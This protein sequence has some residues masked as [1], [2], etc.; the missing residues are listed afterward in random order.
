VCAFAECQVRGPIRAGVKQAGAIAE[1]LRVHVGGRVAHVDGFPGSDR[2]AV[3]GHRAAG[4]DQVD[5]EHQPA[6]AALIGQAAH[7][8]RPPGG[9]GGVPVVA[10]FQDHA[11][12]AGRRRGL[13]LVA[14]DDQ[15]QLRGQLA[16]GDLAAVARVDQVA[17]QA[18]G[19]PAVVLVED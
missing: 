16:A 12:Q 8:G 18:L 14:E 11:D 15:R 17:G 1:P 4:R 13:R 3:D 6:A 2:A 19:Q 5:R 7:Q 10:V 9:D